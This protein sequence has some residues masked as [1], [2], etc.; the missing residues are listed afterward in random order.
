MPKK[1]IEVDWNF[2]DMLKKETKELKFGFAPIVK[3]TKKGKTEIK[4]SL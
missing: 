1:L 2:S 3:I 4:E